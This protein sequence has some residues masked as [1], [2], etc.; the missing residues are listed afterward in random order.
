MILLA[1]DGSNGVDSPDDAGDGNRELLR[2]HRRGLSSD[3][4]GKNALMVD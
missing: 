3:S 2:N 1:D 4:G